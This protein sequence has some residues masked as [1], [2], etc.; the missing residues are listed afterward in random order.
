MNQPTWPPDVA[1]IAAAQDGDRDALGSIL[2]AGHPRL[3]GFFRGAGPQRA[4]AED[5]ASQTCEA[6]V[7]SIKKL[8]EAQAFEGWFWAIAR[9]NLK[10]WIR[11]T[12]REKRYPPSDLAPRQPDEAFDEVEDHASMRQALASLSDND[13][14][15][16]WLRE[17]EELSYD[18][19]SSKLGTSAATIRVA[20][21]RARQR[22]SESFAAIDPPDQLKEPIP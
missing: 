13:R 7:K 5:L 10:G 15:I 14:Q 11:K 4:D 1:V 21:H 19:I 20:C 18:D 17:V 16:L 8:R 22:L 12:R 6:I 9:T 2:R 3:V